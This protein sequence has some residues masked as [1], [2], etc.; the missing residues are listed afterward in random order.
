MSIFASEQI[1]YQG[2]K[3]STAGDIG[4]FNYQLGHFADYSFSPHK[5]NKKLMTN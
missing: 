3:T 1:K 2:N 4:P 5:S